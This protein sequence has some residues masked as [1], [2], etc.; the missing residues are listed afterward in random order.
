MEQVQG[1]GICPF[2]RNLVIQKRSSRHLSGMG[3]IRHVVCRI[4]V[5]QLDALFVQQLRKVTVPFGF[6]KNSDW[7]GRSRERITLPLVVAKEKQLVFLDG[8][9]DCAA[10]HV[11]SHP[12]F[13]T[14]G[15]STAPVAFPAIGI[16]RIIAE[17]L[18]QT[19]R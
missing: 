8:S 3:G 10:K 13:R 12:V 15:G 11:P 6:G 17:E 14:A 7:D 1:D 2:Y 16:E 9:R 18:K 19:S 4:G 5:V